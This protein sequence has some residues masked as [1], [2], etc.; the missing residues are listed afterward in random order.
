MKH[1]IHIQ[2]EGFENLVRGS[3]IS[4]DDVIR[5]APDNWYLEAQD[6]LDLGLVEHVI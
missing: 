1:S 5:R 6:A 2:N 4:L 3:S